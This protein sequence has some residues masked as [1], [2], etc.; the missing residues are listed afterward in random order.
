MKK[1]ATKKA[2]RKKRARRAAGP[3]MPTPYSAYCI[4]LENNALDLYRCYPD[5]SIAEKRNDGFYRGKGRVVPVQIA[6][7]KE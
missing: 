1:A 6:A 2:T 5:K 3:L 4:V 7:V